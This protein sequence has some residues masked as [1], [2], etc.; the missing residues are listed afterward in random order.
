MLI[1]GVALLAAGRAGGIQV[2]EQIAF[3]VSLLGVVLL[4]FGVAVRA[5]A[6]ASL[7]Y[8]LLMVPLWDGFTEP[9][10]WPFQQRS[11]AIGPGCA[12]GHRHSGVSRGHCHRTAEPDRSKSRARAAASTI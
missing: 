6:W 3:L 5:V 11:A 1:A 2:L 9:L 10:H 7:A 12:A 8:L 4:L